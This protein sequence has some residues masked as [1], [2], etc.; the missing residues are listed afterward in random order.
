MKRKTTFL[1]KALTLLFVA[2][3]TLTGA[4]AQKTLPYEYGFENN[5]LAAE[6]WT[7]VNQG[8]NAQNIEEFGITGEAA[9]TGGTYGFRFSSFYSETTSYNQYLISPQLNVIFGDVKVQFS[10]KAS[11]SWGTETF[12][13]GYSTTDANLSSFT[14][15]DE[16]STNNTSWTLYEGTFPAGTK[17][18]AVFYYPEYQWRLYVDNF[19]FEEDDAVIISGNQ[20]F[21]TQTTVTITPKVDG[22]TILY[23]TDNG[24]SWNTYQGE[25]TL[26]QTTTVI[27]KATKDGL[28]SSEVSK[29]FV[30]SGD[31]DDFMWNLQRTPTGDI[32][33][34]SV[35][36]TDAS[37]GTSTNAKM[38]LAKGTSSYNASYYLGGSYGHTRMYTGQTLT[39]EPVGDYV[40]TSIEMTATSNNQGNNLYNRMTLSN[41]KKA[42]TNNSTLVTIT[43]TDGTVPVVATF[44]G[45]VRVTGVTVKYAPASS[46]YIAIWAQDKKVN[47][48]SA[49]V[50]TT[51]LNTVYNR[52]DNSDAAVV[53]CDANGNATNYN[54]ITVGLDSNKKLT[55]TIDHNTTTSNRTAYVKVTA[56]GISSPVIAIIQ[57]AA[58]VLA[59]DGDNSDLIMEH[60]GEKCC[61]ILDGRTFSTGKW[62]TLCL[63]FNVDLNAAG[64]PL[65][66]ADARELDEDNTNTRIEGKT[67]KLE[68]KR[69]DVLEAGQPYIIRWESGANIVNPAFA[70]VTIVPESNPSICNFDDGK[71]VYFNGSYA[72]QSFEAPDKTTIFIS[73]NKFYY[74]GSGTTI[75]AQRG[76]FKLNGFSYDPGSTSTGVKEFGIT[77]DEE[78]PTGIED[79]NVNL[80]DNDN[81]SIYNLAGQRISKMQ[82]GINIVNGKK[83]FVK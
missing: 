37:D 31:I 41:A 53:L 51:T 32:S 42:H 57:A 28:E 7:K 44:S 54:W 49:S 35:T 48:T 5:D 45:E 1:T 73:S 14:F 33:E 61:V 13:V 43:P 15:G 58:I 19:S 68:F 34:G 29:V 64:C 20:E 60:S 66:G 10:Y 81:E 50:P 56:G 69:V 67:L 3:F 59:N 76:Y 47:V 25:F 72:Y 80:N 21:D 17:Y 62:Y 79:V 40:I 27:A 46:P 63:P 36:W 30:K 16:I 11:S 77:F 18:V 83:I 12:K 24:T 2:L 55:Y 52:V 4:R 8:S 38:T 23:S 70:D 82:K 26:T 22:V 9:Q 78:D 6:G 71:S 75:G 65:E 74:V 39:F